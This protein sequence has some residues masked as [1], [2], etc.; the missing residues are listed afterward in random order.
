MSSA[1]VGS[2]RLTDSSLSVDADA[3]SAYVTSLENLVI[4]RFSND[5][6]HYNHIDMGL[7]QTQSVADAQ[8]QIG[9]RKH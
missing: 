7:K 8:I 3:R 5:V 2:A 6:T 4:T 9:R 1:V